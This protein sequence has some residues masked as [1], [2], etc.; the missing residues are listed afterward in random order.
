[1]S[2][3]V[4]F[5]RLIGVLDSLGV[6]Y[7]VGG[8]VA[9]SVHGIPRLTNDVDLV[10]DIKWNKV[11]ALAAALQPDF[12]ADEDI[13]KSATRHGRSFNLIHF[14]SAYKFDV[15]P[16][17][18]SRFR[19]SEFTRRVMTMSPQF[20]DLRFPVASAE[21]TVL[22]KLEW[23]RLGGEISDRQWN[24]IIGVIRVRAGR[25]DLDYLRRWAVEL[26]VSDLLERALSQ[27]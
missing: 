25:L 10:A 18:G 6:P 16:L 26:R 19:E 1:M 27:P 23:F 4:G 15:F 13:I 9:S 14:K 5:K 20:G 24:D 8:S 3:A 22:S 21:D 7:L 11:E 2:L 17:A 12:Y